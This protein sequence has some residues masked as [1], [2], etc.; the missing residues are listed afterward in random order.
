M[1]YEYRMVRAPFLR[2]L[3]AR[4]RRFRRNLSDAVMFFRAKPLPVPGDRDD[5]RLHYGRLDMMSMR[6]HDGK[7]V[8]DF[9]KNEGLV[10]GT[11]SVLVRFYS[12]PR[13]PVAAYGEEYCCL[14]SRKFLI[15][16]AKTYSTGLGESGPP[17][18]RPFE[19][20]N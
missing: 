15:R 17:G 13:G 5:W 16:L 1:E 2:N 6:T 20:T 8:L 3:R 4:W 18:K 7:Q 10:S 11:D 12:N 9:A 14:M 19:L